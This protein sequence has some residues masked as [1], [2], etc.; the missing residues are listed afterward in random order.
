MR[1]LTEKVEQLEEEK[2]LLETK[3]KETENLIEMKEKRAE[4]YK[5]YIQKKEQELCELKRKE[6]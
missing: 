2:I 1:E 3:M 4:E 6:E 5:A